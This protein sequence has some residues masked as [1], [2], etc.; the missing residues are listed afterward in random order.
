MSLAAYI[1]GD[2]DKVR[3]IAAKLGDRVN[4]QNA[5]VIRA[6]APDSTFAH[7]DVLASVLR[8]HDNEVEVANLYHNGGHFFLAKEREES[9]LLIGLGMLDAA[10]ARYGIEYNWHHRGAVHYWRSQIIERILD[11]SAALEPARESLYYW[12]Q[13]CILDPETKRHRE[14]LQNVVQHLEK[15]LS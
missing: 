3:G 15:L 13:Q 1:D 4:V 10:L 5:L 14:Q 12:T 2:D 8:F 6:R 9:D 11:K 7:S